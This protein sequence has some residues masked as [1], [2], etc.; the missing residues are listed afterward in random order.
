MRIAHLS[1][2]HFGHHDPSLAAGLAEDVKRQS[3]TMVVVSGDFTQHGT[4][5]EFEQA[6]EFLAT[7]DAPVLAVPGNHDV[8]MRN[9]VRRLMR[10]YSLY[11]RYIS[12]E[13]EPFVEVDGVA[14]AGI[15]TSRR[16]RLELNW[17]HGTI[18]AK[19]LRQLAARFSK[20]SPTA[21]R[22]V[23]AHHPLLEPDKE[24]AVKMQP[25]R[26]ADEALEAFYELGVRAVLSGHF[27]LS[28]VRQYGGRGSNASNAG[29]KNAAAAPILVIQASSTISTRL[30][31]EPNAYNLV[32][33]STGRI[34][35]T[36]REWRGDAWVTRA[37]ASAQS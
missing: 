25:V 20:A 13:L 27:H 15:R 19:Q 32:D 3:P 16:A 26:Q 22:I 12:S 9:I 29:L 17:A 1:D 14:I 35:A 6:G 7:L 21:T 31:G 28:Y 5:S 11:R 33:V 10:P 4:R 8:P 34:T 36:V 30:R 2:L 24:T 18:S 37:E 23:V